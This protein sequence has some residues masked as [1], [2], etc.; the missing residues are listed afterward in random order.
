MK[1]LIVKAPLEKSNK[2]VKIIL[3]MLLCFRLNNLIIKS[4][5]VEKK[6]LKLQTVKIVVVDA[7]IDFTMPLNKPK[8]LLS[9]T[10]IL[11]LLPLFSKVL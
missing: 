6:T 5:R 4:Q 9:L 11:H 10:P 7:L 8:L 2:T 3:Q 1:L